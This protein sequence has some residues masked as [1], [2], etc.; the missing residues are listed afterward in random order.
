MRGIVKDISILVFS[1]FAAFLLSLEFGVLDVEEHITTIFVFAVFLISLS[2]SSY[3][4][5]V[6]ASILGVVL[7]NYVFTYPFFAFDFI[8]PVNL[9][10]AF[11][12]LT[13]SIVTSL[14]VSRRKESEK[15]ERESEKERTRADLLRA[16]SHDLR[17]PLTTIESASSLLLENPALK[18]EEKKEM[19]LNI[20]EEAEWL[21]RMVENLLSITKLGEKEIKIE[22]EIVIVDELIDSVV[23]KFHKR[24]ENEKVEVL[25]PDEITAVL[26]DPLLIEEVLLNFLD[27]AHKHAEGHSRIILSVKKEG[28]DV[29]FA[30]RDNGC[31]LREK[32]ED[33]FSSY[34]TDGDRNRYR[35]IG[36]SVAKT[37]IV[38]HGGRIGAVNR[39][40]GGAEFYFTLKGGDK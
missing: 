24:Y 5:G 2:T 16:V 12:M 4:Y 27:N 7:I 28:C 13:I 38:E 26:A 10:S 19:L 18:E 20:K 17:T 30:V 39:K 23:N 40:D 1:L 33:I 3:I 22:K 29:V 8:N 14:L 35:G 15:R 31:G 37:I 9:I 32:R 21:E 11:I 25:L 36:L 6:I 34:G